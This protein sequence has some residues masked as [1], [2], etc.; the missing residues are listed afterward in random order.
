MRVELL[1]TGGALPTP[2]RGWNV[3]FACDTMPV[4]V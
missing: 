4:D 1:G 3:G 2:K